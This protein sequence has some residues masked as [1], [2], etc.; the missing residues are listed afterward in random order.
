[1]KKDCPKLLS[2]R[3]CYTC[4]KEEHL[5]K[6]CPNKRRII[7]GGNL[8]LGRGGGGRPQATGRVF[9]MSGA[10]TSQSGNL[11]QGVCYIAGRCVKVLFDSGATHSFVCR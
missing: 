4:H 10:E 5:S 11:V 2:E 6:D 9:S 8:Q 1:L 7:L 3:K